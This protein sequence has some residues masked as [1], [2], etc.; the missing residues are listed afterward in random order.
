[1]ETP[2]SFFG[3]NRDNAGNKKLQEKFLQLQHD[4]IEI[5]GNGSLLRNEELTVR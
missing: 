5:G 1:M 4:V 3:L 2:G